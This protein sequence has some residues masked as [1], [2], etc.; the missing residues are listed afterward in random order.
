MTYQ[1]NK[2]KT[3]A[4]SIPQHIMF[5]LKAFRD[6]GKTEVTG[7]FI[8]K[9]DN[10]LEVIDAVLVEAEC[11]GATVDISPETMNQLYL[12]C[13]EK[14]IY[15]NQLIWWWHTH[16][17]TSPS[18]S[19]TDES[20]FEELGED[21]VFNAMYILA[22]GDN[23][24]AKISIRD[25]ATGIELEQIISIEHPFEKWDTFPSYEELKA[26]YD[27][28]VKPK[29]YTNVYQGVGAA[30]ARHYNAGANRWQGCQP[31]T[32]GQLPLT[33]VNG[34]KKNQKNSGKNNAKTASGQ[35]DAVGTTNYFTD[36]AVFNK[37]SAEEQDTYLTL[38]G[39]VKSGQLT[40]DEADVMAFQSGLGEGFFTDICIEEWEVAGLAEERNPLGILDA[41]SGY[42]GAEDDDVEYIIDGADNNDEPDDF[43]N[44][45]LHQELDG[46]FK[47]Y[48]Q[49]PAP[50][51]WAELRTKIRSGQVSEEEV[52]AW[53]PLVG[54]Y[55]RFELGR[56]VPIT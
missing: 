30:G 14:K 56:F 53:L 47:L 8:T 2:K 46:L 51:F 18:P 35:N 10:S 17:G 55:K 50:A 52:N 24:Y 45:T 37:L 38:L 44:R 36:E 39:E 29:V 40:P 5:K 21:R 4:L 27:A 23:E 26:D 43:V 9:P 34:Q 19:M 1:Y 48:G 20:T 41:I 25:T 16:P 33:S 3:T 42:A 11:S 54:I 28:K 32:Q 31:R 22:K 49:P 7:F 6:M 13:A 12:D 15:T